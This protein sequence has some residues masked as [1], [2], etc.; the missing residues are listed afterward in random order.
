MSVN[1]TNKDYRFGDK[2]RWRW[3]MWKRLSRKVNPKTARCLVMPGQSSNDLFV[4]KSLGF[5]LKNV[6]ALEVDKDAASKI[7][8]T[9]GV[10]TISLPVLDFI[11]YRSIANTGIDAFDVIFLDFCGGATVDNMTCI[12][13][14][15]GS[16]RNGRGYVVANLLRGRDGRK[17]DNTKH[18]GAIVLH[19]LLHLS[20]DPLLRLDSIPK[21]HPP[22][23][24]FKLFDASLHSYKSG[25]LRM[26]SLMCGVLHKDGFKHTTDIEYEA[27]SW[28]I[29]MGDK[30]DVTTDEIVGLS[31]MHRKSDFVR[32]SVA[33]A[34]AVNNRMFYQ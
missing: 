2:N 15:I 26:D 7:R 30:V 28:L 23:T 14:A 22:D 6:V 18:R 5:R 8:K 31:E 34:K 29:G 32:R 12:L 1:G 16:L 13:E 4:M 3:A 24:L 21:I 25:M 9:F 20:N 19:K 33:A 11:Q 27:L 10:L 17:E